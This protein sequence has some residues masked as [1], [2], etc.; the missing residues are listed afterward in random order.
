MPLPLTSVVVLMA[1][2]SNDLDVHMSDQVRDKMAA[3]PEAAEAIRDF[4]AI[5][6]QASHG[7]KTGQYKTMDDAIE[8]LTGSRPE[9]V[10]LDAEDDDE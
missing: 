7:V 1:D 2:D 4:V 5:L 6:R 10:D 9:A 3:D 8:A